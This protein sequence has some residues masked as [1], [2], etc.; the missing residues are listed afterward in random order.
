MMNSG[1]APTVEVE[2]AAFLIGF[3]V[4]CSLIPIIK[5]KPDL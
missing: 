1:V 4:S 5:D 2:Q 3:V